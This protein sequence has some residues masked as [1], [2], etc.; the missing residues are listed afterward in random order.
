MSLLPL[1]YFI[2]ILDEAAFILKRMQT[3]SKSEFLSDETLRRAVVRS[4][5]II[6]EAVKKLP[7]E[8]KNKY[9]YIEWKSIAGM[10]DKLIHNY[11]GVDYE[12]VYDI[13]IN[14]IPTLHKNI[15]KI[16]KSESGNVN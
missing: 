14:K 5:E 13:S 6:G 11:I 8:F 9:N 12:L 3:V 15:Q 4:L 1:E 16:V 2:H 10:R 7:N